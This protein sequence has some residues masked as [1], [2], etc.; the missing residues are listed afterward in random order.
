VRGRFAGSNAIPASGKEASIR[1]RREIRVARRPDGDVA[2]GGAEAESVQGRS[3]W[4]PILIVETGG[5]GRVDFTI[6]TRRTRD[7][8]E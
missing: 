2:E 6:T 7:A 1:G 8:N 5:G 4:Q 3:W